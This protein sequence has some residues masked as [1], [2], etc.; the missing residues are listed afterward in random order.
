MFVPAGFTL[1][2]RTLRLLTGSQG[3]NAPTHKDAKTWDF[4]LAHFKGQ[5]FPSKNR[6][7]GM[8]GG[9]NVAHLDK[10]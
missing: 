5:C 10:S 2:W 7:V 9:K 1:S 3:S 6:V 4:R 8:P